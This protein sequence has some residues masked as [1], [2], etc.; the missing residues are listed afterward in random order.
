MLMDP[1]W[2]RGAFIKIIF[3]KINAINSWFLLF[4]QIFH[5]L[6][7]IFDNFMYTMNNAKNTLAEAVDTS[8]LNSARQP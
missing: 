3:L 6:N 1:G 4:I 5:F 8:R 2:L 7:Y